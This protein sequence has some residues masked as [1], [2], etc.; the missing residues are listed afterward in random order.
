MGLE[1]LDDEDED[2]M[3]IRKPGDLYVPAW[4]KVSENTFTLGTSTIEVMPEGVYRIKQD[5]DN[6]VVFAGVN[7][8]AD[9]LVKF[10]NSSITR[11]QKTIELFWKSKKEYEKFKQVYKRGVLLYGKQG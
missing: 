5:S 1:F 2:D 4:G 6:R 11:L 9:D 10:P 3:Y 8:L 7:I